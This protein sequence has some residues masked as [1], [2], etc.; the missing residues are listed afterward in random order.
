[1]IF[2]PTN[3]SQLQ[4]LSLQ[5]PLTA[6][7]YLSPFPRRR[8]P[9]APGRPKLKRST[10]AEIQSMSNHSNILYVEK[11]I[12]KYMIQIII[13]YNYTYYII[14][15]IIYMYNYREKMYFKEIII[16]NT[17]SHHSRHSRHEIFSHDSSL[18]IFEVCS[19][20][21][22]YGH[23]EALLCC[24]LV[25]SLASMYRFF[26]PKVNSV[27]YKYGEVVSCDPFSYLYIYIYLLYLFEKHIAR[28]SCFKNS[29]RKILELLNTLHVKLNNT[30]S[31]FD[32]P[33]SGFC[34]VLSLKRSCACLSLSRPFVVDPMTHVLCKASARFDEVIMNRAATIATRPVLLLAFESSK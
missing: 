8:S 30:P 14:Y 1:M 27:N 32:F 6:S 18:Q 2:L 33:C 11:N 21:D 10:Q 26:T 12:I 17:N 19:G 7:A 20:P 22:L 23:L 5:P 28:L 25:L 16:K 29:L 34:S 31:L 3:L 24:L 15:M 4:R 9:P 13:L